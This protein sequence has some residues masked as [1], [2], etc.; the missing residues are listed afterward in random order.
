MQHVMITDFDKSL[1]HCAVSVNLL[2]WKV[3]Q[4]KAYNEKPANNDPRK[5]LRDADAA[6]D[7]APQQ[8]AGRQLE[9]C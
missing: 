8:D 6:A 2:N 7:H 5:I 9:K 3:P 4:L 1:S